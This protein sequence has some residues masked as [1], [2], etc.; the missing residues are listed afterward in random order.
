MVLNDIP[1]LIAQEL[2]IKEHQVNATI[3]LLDSGNTIPFI[4]R[5]RKEVTGELNEEHIR[6]IDERIQYLRNLIKR[7]EQILSSIEQQG[8]LTPQLT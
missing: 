5:Y 2:K 1:S 4:S 6:L 3:D 8:K 7:Q